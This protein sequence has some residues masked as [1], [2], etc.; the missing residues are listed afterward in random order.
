MDLRQTTPLNLRPLCVPVGITISLSPRGFSVW[1][2]PLFGHCSTAMKT[3][4]TLGSFRLILTGNRVLLCSG[5]SLTGVPSVVRCEPSSKL[6]VL[7]A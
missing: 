4:V 3:S 1:R 7:F 2:M 6:T 5:N